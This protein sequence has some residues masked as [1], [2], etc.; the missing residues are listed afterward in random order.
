MD[1]EPVCEL[2]VLKAKDILRL[3]ELLFPMVVFRSALRNSMWQA[4][5][6]SGSSPY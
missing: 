5:L 3:V 2:F 1:L 4:M 6:E